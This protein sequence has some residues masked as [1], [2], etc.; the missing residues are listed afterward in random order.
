[1]TIAA[2]I[3]LVII[4]IFLLL[5]LDY[6]LGRLFHIKKA[7]N[8]SYPLRK[9]NPLLFTTGESLFL[10]YFAEI[11]KA[12][13]HIHILFY[14]IRDDKISNDFFSLLSEK[15]KQG[16]EIRMLIDWVGCG[17]KR[18]T[19]RN[20]KKH[21]IMFSFSNKPRFPFFFYSLN[22]RNH[23]KIT[24]I[25][26]K[27]GYIGGFN[28]GEEY[29][30]HVKRF[31][32]WRDYHLKLIGETVQDLQ[33]QFLADWQQATKTDL[34]L[35]NKY[36]PVLEEGNISMRI[37]PTDGVFL[38]ARFLELIKLA[39]QE[40]IIGT[41]YFIPGKKIADELISAARHGITIK[42]IIPMKADHPFVK[43]A[44]IPYLKPLIDNGVSFY[45]FSKGFYHAKVLA[46]DNF[47]CDIGT[48]NLDKRS[49]FLNQ[50]INCFIYDSDYIRY[51]KSTLY[52]DIA[53]SHRLTLEDLNNRTILQRSKERI[54]TFISD[55]L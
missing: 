13:H 33:T 28:V 12:K 39:K 41:P 23:R 53:D 11:A 29:L 5:R 38:Q 14:I 42:V 1:M 32:F 27:I 21:G 55:F 46:I 40:I 3:I 16:V 24:V 25:D 45:L 34:L 26:G 43:D 50:E 37:V 54:S 52:K 49:L 44:A 47:I 19:I 51:I 17:M 4:F 7:S 35:E 31:G 22:A 2:L 9:S 30:G 15:A 48:A 18:K 6:Q 20:L 8:R 36:F 10:D